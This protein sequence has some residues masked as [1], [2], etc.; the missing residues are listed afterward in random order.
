MWGLVRI[1]LLIGN[2]AFLVTLAYFYSTKCLPQG[3]D[4]VPVYGLTIFLVVNF[5]Y[6]LLSK[7]PNWRIS[8][9]LVFGSTPKKANS[10]GALDKTSDAAPSE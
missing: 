10:A 4:Q 3:G 9:S 8:V 5:V 1:I 2:A 7:G 6:L